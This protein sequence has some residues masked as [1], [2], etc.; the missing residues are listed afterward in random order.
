MS[1]IAATLRRFARS[2][3]GK[4]VRAPLT[5]APRERPLPILWGKLL[6]KKWI[7]GSSFQSCWLGIYEY[8]KQ[9]LF[10]DSIRPGQ[11]VFDIGANVGFY[12]LL[13]SHLVGPSGRVVS[14]EPLPRNLGYLHRHL[15]ANRIQ[16]VTVF[17]GAVSNYTGTAHFD[18]GVVPEMAHLATSGGIEVKVFKLDD[19][20]AAGLVPGPD[21]LKIDVEGAEADVIRGAEKLIRDHRPK[22]LLATHNDT[23][24][25]EC[26]GLLEERGYGVRLLDDGHG[27]PYRE[28]QATFAAS[29]A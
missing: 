18:A 26:W 12:T 25:E 8:E 17:E 19:L 21:L 9:R 2:G 11:T 5:L 28:V 23:V 16:N 27:T 14:F 10:V 20:L 29:A 4:I 13:A 22:I 6:G 3:L 1:N 24:H 15:A 7:V